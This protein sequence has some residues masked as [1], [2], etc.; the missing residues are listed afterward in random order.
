MNY[1]L[2]TPR[3]RDDETL[4]RSIFEKQIQFAKQLGKKQICFMEIVQDENHP[5]KSLD[6]T[7][8]EPWGDMIKGYKNMGLSLTL[9]WPTLQADGSAK[10]EEHIVQFYILDL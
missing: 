9:S 6:S 10:E 5:L 4:V 7:S 3:L 1:F 8:P 2:V